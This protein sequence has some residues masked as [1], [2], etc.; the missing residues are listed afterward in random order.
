M[1]QTQH[2]KIKKSTIKFWGGAN[3]WEGHC[4]SSDTGTIWVGCGDHILYGALPPWIARENWLLSW[5][6]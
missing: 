4:P 5:I 2:F 6:T 1:H 3:F